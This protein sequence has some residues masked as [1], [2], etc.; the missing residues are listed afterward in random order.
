MK[1]NFQKESDVTASKLKKFEEILDNKTAVVLHH[2]EYCGHCIAM[3]D[4]FDKFKEETKDHVVE[5]EGGAL[6]KVSQHKKVYSKVGPKDGQMYFPMILVFIRRETM[7]TPKKIEYQGPRTAD[8]LKAFIEEQK[9]KTKS[10][11]KKPVSKSKHGSH[12]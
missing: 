2:S 11:K 8:A 7:V 4:E 1:I 12:K 6:S 3:R 9:Q 5:I 10:L